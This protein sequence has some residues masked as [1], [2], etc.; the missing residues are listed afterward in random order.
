MEK[1]SL[2]NRTVKY[3]PLGLAVVAAVT[4]GLAHLRKAPVTDCDE[5][6]ESPEEIAAQR[7][8]MEAS[9]LPSDKG[10]HLNPRQSLDSH[11]TRLLIVCNLKRQKKQS[12]HLAKFSE[13]SEHPLRGNFLR[14]IAILRGTYYRRPNGR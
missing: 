13:Y 8:T 11:I 3:Y 9:R 12:L 6:K 4:Y 5:N 2:P 10:G 1:A 7:A 14:G